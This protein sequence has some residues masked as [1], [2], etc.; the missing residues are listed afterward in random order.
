MKNLLVKLSQSVTTLIWIFLGFFSLPILADSFEGEKKDQVNIE[1]WQCQYC[2]VQP[3]WNSEISV[4]MGLLSDDVY[5]FS[6][7]SGF[8]DNQIFLSG[9]INYLKD[10]GEYWINE[11]KNVGTDAIQLSSRYGVQG[12]YGIEIN[13]QSIPIRPF[14]N[15]VTPFENPGSNVLRLNDN[16]DRS[17]NSA[18]FD[19]LTQF[20]NFK[21]GSDWDQLGL[22]FSFIQDSHFDYKFDYTRIE[23][24]GII[25]SSA[26]QL[27]Q[28]TFI[29][30]PVNSDTEEFSARVNYLNEEWFAS[31][32]V[33]F[34]SFE[35]NINSVTYAN[36]FSPLGSGASVSTLST[37]P[38]NQAFYVNFNA[39]YSYM[40]RSFVKIYYSYGQLTQNDDFLPF[41]TNS[42]LLEPLPQASL[43]GEII[44]QNV[45]LK[46]NYWFNKKWSLRAKY[47]YRD[48]YNKTD[49]QI[50]RPIL[51]DLFLSEAIVNIPYDLTRKNDNIYLD[52]RVA[53]RQL[54]SLGLENK[55]TERQFQTIRK[56]SDKIISAKYRASYGNQFQ[57]QVRAEKA[58]RSG[59]A[60]E[61]IDLLSVD[62]NPLL[63][64][65][66]VADRD[67]KKLS[68]MFTYIPSDTVSM[69]LSSY[70]A[71]DDYDQTEI[72]LQY[73]WQNNINLDLS[74]HAMDNLDFSFFAEV[75]KIET[76]L[77]GSERFSGRDWLVHNKDEIVSYG[78]SFVIKEL[79]DT[80]L[81]LTGS[82]QISDADSLISINNSGVNS[83]LP[84]TDSFWQVADLK[85]DFRY[86]EKVS[87][88]LNYA[89]Q[90]FERRD[91]SIDEV[92]PG[93]AANLLTFSALSN[94]Y[95]T[96]YLVL[97]ASYRF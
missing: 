82:L 83:R 89:Y 62:E 8:E 75:E 63:Q 86:S 65:F 17:N 37:A 84:N 20:T 56:T 91:F 12:V 50:Y 85:A 60:A 3:T 48:R 19:D 22:K 78:V 81:K 97:S 42:A 73:S 40:P 39:R 74:W 69:I 14:D 57:L 76:D 10:D 4:N 11:F 25:G 58:S 43:G 5:H 33:R 90:D 77:G 88:A 49:L 44:T 72:G 51:S 68:F 31:L 79:L 6:N 2:P 18:N 36:P 80:R 24:K 54:L 9:N 61:L 66:N 95:N 64:R 7:Y 96:H 53:N 59:S 47:N 41:T 23:K 34:S 93:A 87:I 71:E 26:N 35:N 55:K 52:W 70:Y 94:N 30:L 1:N 15:L 92:I 21:L 28:A 27:F 67:N 46:M 13:L 38:D 29:P 45:S 32:G 16:W